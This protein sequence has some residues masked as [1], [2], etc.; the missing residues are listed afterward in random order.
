MKYLLLLGLVAVI[1]WGWSKRKV[2][3]DAAPP[4]RPSPGAEKMVSCAHCGVYLPESDSI[5]D[6]GL[7]YCCETHREQGRSAGR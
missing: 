7:S 1:W 4:S 6:G 5:S 2:V 3:A